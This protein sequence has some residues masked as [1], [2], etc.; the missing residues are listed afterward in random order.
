[1]A[2]E[3]IRVSYNRQPDLIVAKHFEM[4]TN[5]SIIPKKKFSFYFS[6][7]E[8]RYQLQSL[9]LTDKNASLNV[10]QKQRAA[11]R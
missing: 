10:M 9:D 4:S 3:K 2:K 7:L 11:L 5:Y 1:M 8:S 6:V